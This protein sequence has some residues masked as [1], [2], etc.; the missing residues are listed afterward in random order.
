MKFKKITACMLAGAMAL[1]AALTGCGSSIDANAVGATLNGEEISLG[2]MN[3]M[4][5]YQQA[6]Y[7]ASF[8][9][10]FGTEMWSSELSEG[11]TMEDSTKASVADNIEILYL[12]EDHMADYGVEITDEDTAAIEEAAKKF[13][14]DNSDK[15]IKQVGATE[16][17]VKEMLRLYTIQNRMQQAIYE[18][19]DT[20]VSDEEAAQRTFSYIRVDLNNTKDADGNTVALTDEEKETLKTTVEGIL[21]EAKTDYDAA[22]AAYKETYSSATYS[23]GSDETSMDEAVIA[24]ADAL[25]EGE[26]SDLITTEDYYYIIRLESEFDEEATETKKESIISQRKNDHYQEVCEGYKEEAEFVINEGEWDKVSFD[27]L[28]SVVTSEE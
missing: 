7:D 9:A 11:T 12:L 4:A 23:Y 22:A 25:S 5:K 14:S 26:V 21:E 18:E 27:R 8:L 3:F 20:E 15:A 28:F 10:Y 2:F 24:A 6:T 16:E 1:S 19:T 17:Y 13:M